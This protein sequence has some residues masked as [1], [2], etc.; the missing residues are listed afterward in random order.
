MRRGL[1]QFTPLPM[2]SEAIEKVNEIAEKQGMSD[3]L[4]FG[5]Q[6]G[7]SLWDESTEHY[8]DY[9]KDPED[10]EDPEDP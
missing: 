5:D 6:H 8:D 3:E 4:N 2:P 9:D 7:A 1:K 10:P